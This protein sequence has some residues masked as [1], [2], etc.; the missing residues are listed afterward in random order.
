MVV[1]VVVADLLLITIILPYYNEVS[2][3]VLSC[4]NQHIYITH[5]QTH[6]NTQ[7]WTNDHDLMSTAHVSAYIFYR[8]HTLPPSNC[9]A[10]DFNN[11]QVVVTSVY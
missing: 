2:S 5:I 6:W 7:V 3:I 4:T 8:N 1:F 9:F 11:N 10:S